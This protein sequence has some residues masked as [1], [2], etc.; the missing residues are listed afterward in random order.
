MY[1]L[2]I[3][4]NILQDVN[5]EYPM[6]E[7]DR[8][9]VTDADRYTVFSLWDTYRNVH[10]LNT[11]IFPD[12]QVDMIN[13]MLGMYKEWGWLPRW[14]LYGR[15]TWNGDGCRDGNSTGARHSPWRATR[16]CPSSPTLGSEG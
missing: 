6:M 15:E 7:S 4:P 16:R 11:L 12:R 5:G 10:I 1:H 2:Q 13:S 3:H 8:I 9:G 14:E